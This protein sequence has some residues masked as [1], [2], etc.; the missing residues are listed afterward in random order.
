MRSKITLGELAKLSD[1]AGGGRWVHPDEVDFGSVTTGTAPNELLTDQWSGFL[2]LKMPKTGDVPVCQ[3]VADIVELTE[4]FGS[5][6]TIY[7]LDTYVGYL[8]GKSPDRKAILQ[9]LI[10]ARERAPQHLKQ[11]WSDL[12][13]DCSDATLQR[14]WPTGRE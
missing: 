4:R 11:A 10:E 3:I 2:A 8:V 1:Q 5:S 6:Y 13:T 7:N 14:L 9:R 12:I